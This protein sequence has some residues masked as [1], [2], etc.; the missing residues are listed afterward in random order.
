MIA[1][2][3]AR[4]LP[5]TRIVSGHSSKRVWTTA[6]ALAET[7][8]A[9]ARGD[10]SSFRQPVTAVHVA[11][12][13]QRNLQKIQQL[14]SF[15]DIFDIDRGSCS[16]AEV[17]ESVAAM[18]RHQRRRNVALFPSKQNG[19]SAATVGLSLRVLQREQPSGL[20]SDH[21]DS[22]AN[23]G[24]LGI[25]ESVWVYGTCRQDGHKTISHTHG[26][27][28]ARDCSALTRHF[29]GRQSADDDDRY[30]VFLGHVPG[31]CLRL[32]VQSSDQFVVADDGRSLNGI[33]EPF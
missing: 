11:T 4:R 9:F 22:V 3:S 29:I 27:A 32:I 21:Q 10:A 24:Y 33:P 5:W 2:S 31:E 18:S 19:S 26:V 8:T 13:I 28:P 15:S 14:F 16:N 20:V 25:P 7:G 30:I 23:G 17:Q 12:P 1:S 6:T